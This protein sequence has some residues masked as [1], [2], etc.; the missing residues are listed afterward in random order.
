MNSNAPRNWKLFERLV[1]AIHH[2]ESRGAKVVWNDKINRRQFN[3]TV[4][5]QHGLYQYL[6]VIECRD[7]QRPV[8]VDKVEAYVTK[9]RDAKADKA[10]M[11]SSSGYQDG[12]IEVANRHNIELFTLEEINQIP[13]YIL[14]AKLTPALN[15]YAIELHSQRGSFILPE[16]RNILTYLIRHTRVRYE[17]K[18]LSI[19]ELINSNMVQL[20]K[21]I[22]EREKILEIP[23]SSD[24]TTQIP[25]LNVEVNATSVSFKYRI[26]PAKLIEQPTLDPYVLDGL[27]KSYR[28]EDI[29][30]GTAKIFQS[31]DLNLGFDT[32][33]EQGKFY[34]SPNLG[35][36]YFCCGIENNLA[37]M[38]L[39]ESY[40]HGTLFQ[41][42]FK[43][44]VKY[45]GRYIEVT[46]VAEIDRLRK[47]LS[48]KEKRQ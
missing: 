32:T 19:E 35:F 22:N 47:I 21:N 30:Q 40:Q 15:I 29:I 46:D 12:C 24:F 4:R 5:F 33:L 25:N 39:L 2:S 38:F 17:K 42:K 26:I 20:M 14:S 18:I 8:S 9:S 45:S 10:I 37:T 28:F 27:S 13:N 43:I 11:V 31:Q 41:A 36:Y 6:T 16:D 44:D 34:I 48:K 1:A 3:V 23:L 7:N